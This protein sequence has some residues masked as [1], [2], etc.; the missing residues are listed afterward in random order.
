MQAKV[1]NPDR[2]AVAIVGRIRD[3]LNI[4]AYPEAFLNLGA[5]IRLPRILWSVTQR[6]VTQQEIVATVGQ[7]RCMNAGYS[8]HGKSRSNGIVRPFPSIPGQ[9]D[10]AA[11][12]T[13][14]SCESEAF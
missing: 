6:A 11:R 1:R 14:Y 4:E 10:A 9:G 7:V 13:I 2:A 5:V 3:V 12:Q 8:A